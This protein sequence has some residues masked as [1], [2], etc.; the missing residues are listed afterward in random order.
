M[1][2]KIIR[3]FAEEPPFI[4]LVFSIFPEQRFHRIGNPR[5]ISVAELGDKFSLN[6][7]YIAIFI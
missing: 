1:T 4:E 7:Y 2:F 6:S 3:I 5:W